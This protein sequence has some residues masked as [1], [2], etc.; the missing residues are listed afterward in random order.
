[1]Q[2]WQT[3]LV[4]QEGILGKEIVEKWLRPLKV[5]RF[6]AGNI[7]LEAADHFQALWFEEHAKAKAQSFFS[8][9]ANRKFKIHLSISTEKK[10]P[11]A[12][13]IPKKELKPVK[14]AAVAPFML[15]FD[16][17]HPHF[18]LEEYFSSPN[19]QVPVQLIKETIE[20]HPNSNFNPIYLY[21]RSA[22]GKT[23]LLMAAAAA[24]R[25]K[26]IKALYTRAETFTDHVVG[27]IRAGE[28]S[29]FRETYRN[30]DVLIVDDVHLFSR[31]G[32]TQ[33]EFF[34]TFNTLHLSGKQILLS[35]NCAPQELDLIEPRLISRFEWGIVL[36]LEPLSQAEMREVVRQ[37]AMALQFPLN[38]RILDFLLEIFPT[39]LKSVVKGLEA[40]I[41]RS[42]L[43]N[44][45]SSTSLTVPAVK[46]I[47]SDLIADEEKN[48]LTPGR[49]L[50]GVAEFFGIR[51]EDLQGKSQA[52]E[53]V[54]PRQLAM[55]L[56]RSQLKL[57]YMKI[58][59]LFSRDH[60]TVMSAIKKVDEG[61]AE[62]DNALHTARTAILK[63]LH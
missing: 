11:Q 58:G 47:L 18:T 15:L 17:L 42:H 40:L 51:V 6:D 7:Y 61:I 29:Q 60:S 31:K 35:A 36:P 16:Q 62:G 45:A 63:K 56:C 26:G 12:K 14:G 49:I 22:T 54:L 59:D 39:G 38:E 27:A 9:L 5:L 8:Q 48:A 37:K 53:C 55:Q 2:A 34:H 1:M 57:P 19:N 25:K 30:A 43:Q 4:E 24:Y 20:A 3:F 41:L 50:Q 52:R 33:E 44:R 23:H 21:G 13:K 10:I 28:M 46:N 32:A